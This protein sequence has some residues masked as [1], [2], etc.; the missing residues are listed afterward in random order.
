MPLRRDGRHVS[1]A[2]EVDGL[3]VLGLAL[4]V[5]ADG[6]H[7]G[8]ELPGRAGGG[9]DAGGDCRVVR[10]AVGRVVGVVLLEG[11]DDE[12]AVALGAAARDGVVRRLVVVV[13]VVQHELVHV[14]RSVAQDAD[15]EE[16]RHAADEHAADHGE[17]HLVAQRFGLLVRHD[18][19]ILL[20]RLERR[21]ARAVRQLH[22]QLVERDDAAVLVVVVAL[23][24]VQ[25]LA[26][27]HH[28]AAA[29]A[30]DPEAALTAPGLD[31][32]AVDV[33]LRDAL[34]VLRVAHG[35]EHASVLDHG[36][37]GHVEDAHVLITASNGDVSGT[38]VLPFEGQG[39]CNVIKGETFHGME[40]WGK[41]RP[42]PSAWWATAP[43]P[44]WRRP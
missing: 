36:A 16:G 43:T 22:A 32:R 24:C 23:A 31:W 6:E 42:H 21:E 35:L 26:V 13:H 14:E 8:R 18:V 40:I 12:R 30:L 38:S 34:K 44:S 9:H 17:E 29:V 7:E 37:L 27:V 10:F 15:G 28:D 20:E 2:Q 33:Q 3:G 25:V 41:Q 19:L 5:A 1:S 39:N 11:L 4:L